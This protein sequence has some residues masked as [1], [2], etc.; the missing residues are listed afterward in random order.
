MT[1]PVF[2]RPVG[3][4]NWCRLLT[5]GVASHVTACLARIDA[6]ERLYLTATEPPLELLC[7]AC[8]PDLE[9]RQQ[10]GDAELGP[11]VGVLG[12]RA[13][14]EVGTSGELLHLHHLQDRAAPTP[15]PAIGRAPTRDLRPPRPAVDPAAAWDSSAWDPPSAAPAQTWDEWWAASAGDA[16]ATA[17]E[18][19]DRCAPE[20]A[21]AFDHL[22]D[23]RDPEDA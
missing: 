4:P 7:G 16:D 1:A 18:L 3:Y 14:I 5:V 9:V 19:R 20:D 12:N 13:E 21:T 15:P 23:L 2:V 17:A 6:T 8:G 11:S 22:D 10:R